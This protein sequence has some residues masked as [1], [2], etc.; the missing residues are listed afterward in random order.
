MRL[1]MRLESCRLAVCSKIKKQTSL[2]CTTKKQTAADQAAVTNHSGHAALDSAAV[3]TQLHELVKDDL[4]AAAL[5]PAS[6]RHGLLACDLVITITPSRPVEQV[7]S[8]AHSRSIIQ[9]AS[10]T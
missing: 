5:G 7:C 3:L 1:K 9:F 10:W 8:R 6:T 2:L 4:P